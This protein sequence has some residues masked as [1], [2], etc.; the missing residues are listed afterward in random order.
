MSVNNL[1]LGHRFLK[2]ETNSVTDSGVSACNHSSSMETIYGGGGISSR[3]SYKNHG[4]PFT[5]SGRPKSGQSNLKP[6]F[7]TSIGLPQ[8]VES[9]SSTSSSLSNGDIITNTAASISD[10]NTGNTGNNFTLD[11]VCS[12]YRDEVHGKTQEEKKESIS[13]NQ[14]GHILQVSRNNNKK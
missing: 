1:N 11:R 9:D 12:M 6:A 13:T 10:N 7:K 8:F 2:T 3:D 14:A 4:S 5:L